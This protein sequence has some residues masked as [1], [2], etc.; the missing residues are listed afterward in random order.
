MSSGRFPQ[1][2]LS[3]ETRRR[4]AETWHAMDHNQVNG[5]PDASWC[6]YRCAFDALGRYLDT[7]SPL[8]HEQ[9]ACEYESWLAAKWETNGWGDWY[10]DWRSRDWSL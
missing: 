8:E 10:S 6:C 9:A 7:Q 2:E 1:V 3:A 4:L 5:S